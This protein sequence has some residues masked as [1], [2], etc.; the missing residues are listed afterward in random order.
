MPTAVR[1]SLS[2]LPYRYPR[3]YALRRSSTT[4]A[5]LQLVDEA[6]RRGLLHLS[7]AAH[8]VL[9]RDAEPLSCDLDLLDV[10]GRRDELL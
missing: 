1:S 2:P 6:D 8:A 10:E 4:L 9:V 5:R 7:N 3:V